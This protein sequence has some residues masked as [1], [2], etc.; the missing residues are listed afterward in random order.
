VICV[1]YL[2]RKIIDQVDPEKIMVL[3]EREGEELETLFLL[4]ESVKRV[5]AGPVQ[6]S[7]AET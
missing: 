3:R 7:D 1:N 2:C 6:G 5:L 4:Q